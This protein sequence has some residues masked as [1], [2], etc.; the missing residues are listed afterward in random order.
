MNVVLAV[1]GVVVVDDELDIVHVQ[2]SGSYVG[3]DKDGRTSGP[4]GEKKLYGW[5]ERMKEKLSINVR[6]GKQKS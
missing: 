6:I 4:G 5:I 3:G 1:V 2:P